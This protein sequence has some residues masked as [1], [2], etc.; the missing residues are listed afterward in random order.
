MY[1]QRR[2]SFTSANS[3]DHFHFQDHFHE[4]LTLSKSSFYEEL[5]LVRW[6][7]V[8]LLWQNLCHQRRARWRILG[9]FFE[10]R[11]EVNES[12]VRGFVL[13]RNWVQTLEKWGVCLCVYVFVKG[14]AKVPLSV[15]RVK[16]QWQQLFFQPSTQN[17]SIFCS[18]WKAEA[19][20]IILILI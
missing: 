16:D 6:C 4:C 2:W 8:Y 3:Q 15:K 12:K 13:Q 10:S 19:V 14:S 17:R 11:E 5:W 18:E 9:W 7:P 1:L 20:K